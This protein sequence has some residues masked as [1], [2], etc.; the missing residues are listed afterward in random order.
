MD[1]LANAFTNLVAKTPL[2]AV[3]AQNV[4]LPEAEDK[5]LLADQ[6]GGLESEKC[7]LRIEGMTCG[8]C[9]EVGPSPSRAIAIPDLPCYVS[10]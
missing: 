9:V 8:A 2:S 4:Q 6:K 5:S 10:Q 7:D 3:F 1:G